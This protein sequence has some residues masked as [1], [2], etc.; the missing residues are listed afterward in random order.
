MKRFPLIKGMTVF[1]SAT[2]FFHYP[3]Q[4]PACELFDFYKND[5]VFRIP[6]HLPPPARG[7]GINL[8]ANIACDS[9]RGGGRLLQ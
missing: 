1:F 6:S 9:P 7:G 8:S 4:C 3:F 2:A 5:R